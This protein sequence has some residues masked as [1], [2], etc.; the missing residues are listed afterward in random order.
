MSLPIVTYLTS[1]P[2][3]LVILFGIVSFSYWM[4][5]DATARGSSSPLYWAILGPILWPAALYYLLVVRRANKRRYPP[6]RWQGLA[7]I[8]TISYVGAMVLGFVLGPPDVFTQILYTPV[9]FVILLFITY[10]LVYRRR[11]GRLPEI[12]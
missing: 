8:V 3:L 2:I 12:A 9:Y 1:I 4:R 6:T 10:L 11:Y 5:S 7:G